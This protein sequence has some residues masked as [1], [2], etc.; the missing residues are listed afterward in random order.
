VQELQFQTPGPL[1]RAD[2][3]DHFATTAHGPDLMENAKNAIRSMISWLEDNHSLSPSQAYL[4]CSAAA[5]LM[6]SEIVDAPN[7][8]VSAYIPLKIFQG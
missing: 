1:S 8:I 7:W 2:A 5:D 6:I 4:L 3:K